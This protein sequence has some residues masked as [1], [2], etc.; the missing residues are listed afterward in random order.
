MNQLITNAAIIVSRIV[1]YVALKIAATTPTNSANTIGH[2]FIRNALH[3]LIAAII[4]G[5]GK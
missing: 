2:H 4:G 5:L 3:P 1:V